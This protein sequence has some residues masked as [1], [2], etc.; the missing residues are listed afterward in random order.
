M[1]RQVFLIFLLAAASDLCRCFQPQLPP[2]VRRDSSPHLQ[3]ADLPEMEELPSMDSFRHDIDPPQVVEVRD[4][5]NVTIDDA[6]PLAPPLTFNKFLTM[7][8]KRV[9]T[10][11]CYAD[12][13]G[14]KPYYL[15]A[16]KKIKA[17]HPDVV[18]EKR[19]LPSI[20]GD[21]NFEILVDD[22]LVVSNQRNRKQQRGDSVYVSMQEMDLAIS[23]ARRKRRPTTLYGS[24]EVSTTD[25]AMRLEIL[26]RSREGEK[27]NGE[28][29][30]WND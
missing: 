20:E 30:K 24:D 25:A 3:A 26:K 6:L 19:I 10:T 23:K 13:C 29:S 15:T 7:Q 18:I 12:G 11:I 1:K 2:A 8:D 28:K 16:A 22:K 21:V 4:D 27:V 5:I 17:S 14:L 9:V